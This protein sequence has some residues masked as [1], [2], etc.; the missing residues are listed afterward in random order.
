MPPKC[1]VSGESIEPRRK[2][3]TN[4]A[5]FFFYLIASYKFG[6]TENPKKYCFRL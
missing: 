3:N 1:Q 2:K 5:V 4:K 6:P